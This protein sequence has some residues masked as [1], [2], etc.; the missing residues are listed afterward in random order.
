[1]LELPPQSWKRVSQRLA[2]NAQARRADA[3][4]GLD[5]ISQAHWHTTPTT[6]RFPHNAKPPLTR[7]VVVPREP[8][9]QKHSPPAGD[10]SP[11][12]KTEDSR[13]SLAA[14][15]ARVCAGQPCVATGFGEVGKPKTFG[16]VTGQ[17]ARCCGVVS[18]WL[19][20]LPEAGVSPGHGV[21][22][23]FSEVSQRHR[24]DEIRELGRPWLPRRWRARCHS[25]SSKWLD[26]SFNLFG[27][28]RRRR[29]RRR[30][31]CRF[32]SPSY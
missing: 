19:E 4:A 5:P 23:V 15:V 1:M 29:R 18:C 10:I 21:L 27:I 24:F 2:G 8:Y 11:R 6:P 3:V 14:R 30:R 31:R 20:V 22:H 7:G 28:L 17:L 13:K 12:T 25:T 32:N 16:F 9:G 26:T